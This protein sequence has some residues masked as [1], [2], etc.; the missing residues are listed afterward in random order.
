M[1]P[2]E[3]LAVGRAEAAHYGVTSI[4]AGVV[5]AEHADHHFVVLINEGQTIRARAVLVATGL[6]DQLPPIPGLRELWGSAVHHCPH[7][8]GW[9]VRGRNIVVLGG[10]VPRMTTHQ[11]A[12]LRRYTDRVTLCPGEMELSAADRSQLTSFGVKIITGGI[13]RLVVEDGRLVGLS[14]S[15]GSTVSGEA[16]FIAPRSRPNDDVLR[17]LGCS[18]DPQTGLIHT[19]PNGATSVPG[20]WAA[21]NVSN[22]RAQVITAAGEGSVAGIAISA[23][24]LEHDLAAAQ[25]ATI[26]DGGR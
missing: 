22:P 2:S 21:G 9:E 4:K 10:E 26:R 20:V 24:L 3:F 18:V 15:D 7:C 16:V 13:E 19:D 25:T 11:A 14:L 12:L 1:N 23:W 17:A 6:T 5:S 8:H